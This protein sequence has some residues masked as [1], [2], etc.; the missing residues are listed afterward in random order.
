MK[1]RVR[2]RDR[3][4]KKRSIFQL[5]IFSPN[6]CI[7]WS[8]A[9]LKSE[10]QRFNGVLHLA[11]GTQALGPSSA[12]LPRPSGGSQIGNGITRTQTCAHKGC[13]NYSQPLSLVIPFHLAQFPWVKSRSMKRFQLWFIWKFLNFSNFWKIGSLYLGF[14]AEMFFFFYHFKLPSYPP[15]SLIRN[16]LTVLTGNPPSLVTY[17]PLASF[18]IVVFWTFDYKT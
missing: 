2:E 1:G 18:K 11:A 8:C 7:S 9:R 14:L 17:F 10:P 6:G 5:L 4:R 16:L 15:K 12:T 3:E 13:Q